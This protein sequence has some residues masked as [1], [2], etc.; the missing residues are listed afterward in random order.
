MLRRFAWVLL[1]AA[2]SPPPVLPPDDASR[3]HNPGCVALEPPPS[4]SGLVLEPAFA[5][6]L[7]GV[8]ALMEVAPPTA[9]RPGFAITQDGR[10]LAFDRTGPARGVL[11]LSAG[12]YRGVSESGLVSFAVDPDF[13]GTPHLYTVRT[14]PASGSGLYVA[15][16]ARFVWDGAR[17]D[18]ASE[19][20]ILD[21]PQSDVTHSV[22]HVAFGADGMLYVA[23]GDQRRTD[24]NAQDPA[25]LPGKILRLEV[26]GAAPYEAPPDNP[27]VGTGAPE[28]YAIGFRN[29]WRF[30]VDPVDGA[31]FVG[32][33]GQDS[34]E[35]IDRLMP[36]ANYG[37]P[38]REGT[39]CFRAAICDDTAY[40]DPLV[41]AAHPGVRSIVAGYRY[42]A[43]DVPSLAGRVLFA[44][45]VGGSVWSFDEATGDA[46][47]EVETGGMITSFALDEAGHHHVVRYDP[48]GDT[49]GL[50]RLVAAPPG[51][52]TFPRLLSETGCVDP[53]DPRRFRDGMLAFDPTAE[54]WSDGAEK[55]RAVAVPDGAAIAVGADG[56]FDLPIGSVLVKHFGFAGRLHETRLLMR[57]AGGWNGYSYRWNEAGTDAELLDGRF[58][59]D[60]PSGVRWSYPSRSECATC[61][62]AA[63]GGSLG[64]EAAQLDDA[65][66]GELLDHGWLD[67]RITG[68][69]MLRAV[70]RPPLVDPFGTA[71][72][73][74]RARSYLHANCSGCHRP[75]GPGRGAFDLRYELGFAATGAC[76]A[77]PLERIWDVGVWD[78]QRV[79]VPGR[80]AHSTLYLRTSLHG[81][82]RMPPLGTDVVDEAG[83]ALLGAWIDGLTGCE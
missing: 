62:T 66:L 30:T 64:L 28:V 34:R 17:F 15:R 32:D 67:R 60:L 11:D 54:L 65:T 1:V 47:V 38:G 52:S 22:N 79:I 4:R 63:A 73:A 14:V 58:A 83:V 41:E 68:L 50:F 46:R 57:T 3:P 40:V 12:L 2:C 81:Y 8:R 18:P 71:D 23:L 69:A 72:V 59:E 5:E 25:R 70:S 27:F 26:H 16:I 36:G 56:D 53:D 44:D 33:V 6:A 7:V 31:I 10:V 35:E 21:V 9:L 61:H 48:T 75:G 42:R 51:T 37:W 76:N 43:D 13:P 55:A 45:F 82:F 77:E 29:P 39:L 19:A 24:V 20:V 74:S 78:E 80:A 49:G